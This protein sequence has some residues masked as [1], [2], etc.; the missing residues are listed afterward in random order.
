MTEH[1]PVA[2][3]L[4]LAA[5]AFLTVAGLVMIFSASSV[6]DL[7]KFGDTAYHLK[8]Q[9]LYTALGL[10]LMYALSHIDYR[11]LKPLIW[12][13]LIG[14]DVLC[15]V[16]LLMSRARFGAQRWIDI[17]WF[18]IQPSELAKLCAVAAVALVLAG[19]PPHRRT[20]T[21]LIRQL[22]LILVPAATLIMLQPDMGTTMSMIV[23][24]LF[25]LWLGDFDSRSL[26]VSLAAV[27][28]IVPIAII[29]APYRFRRF[30]AFM[31]PWADPKGN[32]YQIIQAMYAFASGGIRGVGLGLS[33]QKFFYLPAAHTD[34][35]FAIVGEELG[36]IGALA[37]VLAFAVLTY[38]GLRIASRAQDRFGRLLAGGMIVLLA[39]QAAIN[40]LAVTGMMPVTGIPLPFMSYGGSAM[41]LNL[42]LLGVVLSVYRYGNGAVRRT[43]RPEPTSNQE[44][45]IEGPAEWWGNGR[46]HLPGSDRR[47]SASR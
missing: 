23:A 42:G 4:L 27:V 25:V 29:T 47:R 22:A 31:D 7:Q 1:D 18:S 5:A 8:R 37:I 14:A 43:A 46:A 11:R 9:V 12:P 26:A 36:L 19:T 6:A 32:G 13:A 15:L 35:I 28:T 24:V 39:S 21:G 45:V 16:V 30:T 41:I 44:N 10:V 20:I 33:R 38:A 3:Y 17:G 34:F 2:R 40:M